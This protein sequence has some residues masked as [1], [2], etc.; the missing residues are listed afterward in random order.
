MNS[1]ENLKSIPIILITGF[2][3]FRSVDFNPSWEVAKAL[4]TY[5]EWTRSIKIVLEQ[6]QVTYDDVTTKIPRFWSE[7]NPTVN[8]SFNKLDFFSEIL[9]KLVIHLGVAKGTAEIRLER[10]AC[11]TDYC[12]ADNNGLV[13]ETGQCIVENA[14]LVLKTGLPLDNICEQVQKQKP[15]LPVIISENAGR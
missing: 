2:G 7:Y 1:K 4:Q 12:H 13:P 9:K 11:N 3:P 14:S 15:N 8:T 10:Y 6:L 5:L